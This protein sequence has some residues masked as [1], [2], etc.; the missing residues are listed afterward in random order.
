MSKRSW[1]LINSWWLI[2]SFT[3]LLYLNWT[4]FLYIGITARHRRWILYGV[5]Y[6]IPSILF[7]FMAST[8][9]SNEIID[10][11]SI[12]GMIIFIMYSMGLIS[13]IHAF[14]LRKEYLVRLKA[15][16]KVNDDQLRKKIAREYGLSDRVSSDAHE[17]SKVIK[18]EKQAVSDG[19]VKDFHSKSVSSP[20]NI[21]ND[22]EDLLVELPGVNIILA[23][24]TIQLRESGVYFDSAEDFGQALGLKPHTVEKIKPYII[25]NP[26]EEIKIMKNKGRIVD[27]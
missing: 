4:A 19:F 17:N 1:E 25:I 14:Y 18:D 12:Q 13:I 22:P 26:K 2:L 8:W 15:L 6:A 3:F 5:I 21:N 27:I 20:V 10:G 7:S 24:K 23:K 11:N 9:N 16:K